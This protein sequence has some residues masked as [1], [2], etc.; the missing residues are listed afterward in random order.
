MATQGSRGWRTFGLL[1]GMVVV[2][3]LGYYLPQ[4]LERG[5]KS[6]PAPATGQPAPP[7]VQYDEHIVFIDAP[8]GQH[9]VYAIRPDGAERRLLAPIAQYSDFSVSND[10]QQLI[11][12]MPDG[13][14]RSGGKL[15]GASL[16]GGDPRPLADGHVDEASVSPDGSRLVFASG[17]VLFLANADGTRQR[18]LTRPPAD[19]GDYHPRIS[20]DNMQVAFYRDLKDTDAGGDTY[21][22]NTDS[23]KERLLVPGEREPDWSPDG[24]AVVTANLVEDEGQV[25]TVTIT[26]A[27]TRKAEKVKKTTD[28]VVS[29]DG[30]QYAFSTGK[31]IMLM[32]AH[33]KKYHKLPHTV[34]NDFSPEFSPDGK[35]LVFANAASKYD[36][37]VRPALYTIDLD[38]RHRA[39]LTDGRNPRWVR[40]A[41]TAWK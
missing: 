24:R 15:S 7:P 12:L 17:E 1:V 40:R 13:S 20:P 35:R 25:D 38:G 10:G 37:T 6:P 14:N 34:A 21:V 2:G 9:G 16:D 28:L 31:G 11:V 30:S 18:P 23:G 3:A 41:I 39:K 29:P 32:P 33:G 26:D 36:T 27:A 8:G 4:V 22:V 19:Y 5:H